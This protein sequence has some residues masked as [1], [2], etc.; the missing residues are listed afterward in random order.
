MLLIRDNDEKLLLPNASWYKALGLARRNGWHPKGTKWPDDIPLPEEIFRW[1]GDYDRGGGQAMLE[2]DVKN[3][4]E[5]LKQG[6]NNKVELLYELK[7]LV[8]FCESGK[9]SLYP[10]TN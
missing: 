2:E 8:E 3:F 1:E 10:V 5:A 4:M 6:L 9:F 7:P